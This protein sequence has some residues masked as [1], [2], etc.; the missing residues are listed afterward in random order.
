MTT[1]DKIEIAAKRAKIEAEIEGYI[2]CFERAARNNGAARRAGA[3]NI[4]CL[5]KRSAGAKS[6]YN[7]TKAATRFTMDIA[8]L[9]RVG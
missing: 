4:V 6:R 8:A 3:G 2:G 5:G 7:K 9:R 1:N